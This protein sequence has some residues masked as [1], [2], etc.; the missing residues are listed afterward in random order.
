[1]RTSAQTVARHD[2]TI[3]QAGSARGRDGR[4]LSP[5]RYGIGFVDGGRAGTLQRKPQVS[6]GSGIADEPCAK[7]AGKA[8][9]LQR[10][11]SIGSTDD[12]LEHEADRAAD[13]AL[14]GVSG[15]HPS[16]AQ[17]LIRRHAAGPRSGGEPQSGGGAP[18]SV[19]RT[20]AG[21]G[22]PLET[23]VRREMEARFGHDFAGVRVHTDAAAARSAQDVSALAYTAGHAIVFG[24]GQYAPRSAAGRRL[25][26]HELAHVVQQGGGTPQRDTSASTTIRR[27]AAYTVAEQ[28]A[29]KSLNWKHP[30]SAPLRVSDDGEM[31]VEDNGWGANKDKRAWTTAAR[32][33]ASNAILASQLSKVKLKA[34]AGTLTGKAPGSPKTTKSLVEIE[35]LNASTGAAINL[36]A[37]CGSACKEVTGSGSTGKDVAVMN[38]GKGATYTSPRSYHGGDPTTPE[39]W[40]EEIF[41]KEFGAGLTRDQAYA[42][43]D[44]LSAADKTK[45]DRKYGINKFAVPK[46][47]QG[48]TV[49]T[50]KDMPGFT[51]VPGASMTWNFHFAATVLAS[52]A[53]YVTLENAAG[54]QPTDWIFFMYGP[55][56]KGQSFHEFH[57]ATDT[58]GTDWTSMVVQP[59]ATLHVQTNAK[60]APLLV[61]SAITKLDL[62]TPLEVT[63]RAEPD[64]GG[65]VWLDVTVEGGPNSG[66]KG[67]IRSSFVK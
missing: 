46:V 44:A 59:E 16:R 43:Y 8:V 52:G 61:G 54:W 45:F 19:H 57:G 35:P 49:S 28:T 37:D 31:A 3:P 4:R 62:A 39:Q 56:T 66:K 6:P 27:F 64:V 42:K 29:G 51:T 21:S 40:S 32:I 13:A 26:A 36:A 41:K 9:G 67:K 24:A 23:P 15:A 25:L 7:C 30:G 2:E 63:R 1:M 18:D 14:A 55:A 11:L 20:L 22:V 34:K 65:T 10:K 12:P 47:G 50:E 5:P 53:D 33:A 60:D 38:D 58:H 17:P 48:I